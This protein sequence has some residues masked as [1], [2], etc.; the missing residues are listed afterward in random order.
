MCC[1]E[2]CDKS[3]KTEALAVGITRIFL[4][5]HRLIDRYGG[6]KDT[7]L[8]LNSLDSMISEDG[9]FYEIPEVREQI[10]SIKNSSGYA[11]FQPTQNQV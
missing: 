6:K 9:M 3:D 5:L 4:L 8:L 2:C 7:N 11:T 10:Y 1:S